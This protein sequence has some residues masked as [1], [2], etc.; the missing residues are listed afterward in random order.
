MFL[1][2]P[3]ITG[4]GKGLNPYIFTRPL[5]IIYLTDLQSFAPIY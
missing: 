4:M 1:V 3:Q 5:C 2:S